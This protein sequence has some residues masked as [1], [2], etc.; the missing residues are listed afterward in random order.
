MSYLDRKEEAYELVRKAG[1]KDVARVGRSGLVVLVQLCSFGHGRN[2]WDLD[3]SSNTLLQP[4]REFSSSSI[5]FEDRVFPIP[6]E[7]QE[8]T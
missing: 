7:S 2:T 4:E 3:G 5:P 8:A 1:K 6:Q